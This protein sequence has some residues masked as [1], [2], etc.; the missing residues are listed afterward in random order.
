MIEELLLHF[1]IQRQQCEREGEGMCRCVCQRQSV[2][3]YR[4]NGMVRTYR[5]RPA[6]K[7]TCFP[8]LGI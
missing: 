3:V 4:A 8:S 6:E 7:R 1:R 2:T 5:V